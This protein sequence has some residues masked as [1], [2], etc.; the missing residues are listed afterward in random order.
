MDSLVEKRVEIRR[1]G[2][3]EYAAARGLQD[4]LVV[5]RST[6]AICDT[7]L[8]LQHPEILT[9]GK[10]A[11]PEDVAAAER[12][13]LSNGIPVVRADRGGRATYHGPGQLI[14]YPVISLTDRGW[15]V[16]RFVE[17]GLEILAGAARSFGAMCVVR[18]DAAGVWIG[19]KKVGAV[20]L[21]ICRGVTNHGFSLNVTSSLE[22]YRDFSPCGL[23]RD[24]MTSLAAEAG[25]KIEF[26]TVEE[27]V[28][29]RFFE[30]LV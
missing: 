25:S 5:R 7:V 15:G 29:R 8:S 21:R 19:D 4:D 16:K 24:S 27:A 22:R 30:L 18:L 10:R 17:S 28:S 2:V 11:T 3:V 9:L 6:G 1:L 23:P 14:V 20:G 12:F 13:R 26:S